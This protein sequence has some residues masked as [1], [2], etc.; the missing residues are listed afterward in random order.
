MYYTKK[1]AE[2]LGF[3]INSSNTNYYNGSG[4]KK[5]KIEKQY[6]KLTQNKT[7]H[8]KITNGN[9]KKNH[10]FEDGKWKKYKNLKIETTNDKIIGNNN[11]SKKN[12]HY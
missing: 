6:N 7:I 8:N 11:D 5:L 10:Y 2:Q 1:E 4:W 9:N 3:K 12:Y